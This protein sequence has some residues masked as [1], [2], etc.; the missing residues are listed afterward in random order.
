MKI[1]NLALVSSFIFFNGNLAKAIDGHCVANCNTAPPPSNDSYT[2]SYNTHTPTP[3]VPPV[4]T[5]AQKKKAFQ[6]L[7]FSFHQLQ[8]LGAQEFK[9]GNYALA[10]TYF[11][12]A[13]KISPY[14]PVI[15][16]NLKKAR[17][18]AGQ[19]APDKNSTT[20]TPVPSNSGG[21]FQKMKFSFHQLQKL[22]AQEFK[23]GNYDLAITHFENALRI[24]PAHSVI[25]KNLEKAK[26]FA[27][28][29]SAS[30]APAAR[31]PPPSSQGGFSKPK[32]INLKKSNSALN[33]LKEQKKHGDRAKD[34][35]SV[36]EAKHHGRKNWEN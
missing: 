23:N 4:P 27:G 33:Q 6:R 10:V 11:E 16:K 24:Y 7:E 26:R 3:Y 5:A 36:E 9:K 12:K 2:P 19:S 13:L 29:K 22:G 8:K 32:K 21:S 31:R 28:E 15:K 35:K 25:Q 34:A 30:S 18:F 14:H 20:Q 17:R 1:I